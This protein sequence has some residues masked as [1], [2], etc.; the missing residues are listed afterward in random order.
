MRN[1]DK[2]M[3]AEIVLTQDDVTRTPLKIAVDRL[4]RYEPQRDGSIVTYLCE[5][6]LVT[7][8]VREAR[9]DIDALLRIA[10]RPA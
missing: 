6:G 2:K 8:L 9:A 4:V 7:A 5:A 10:A 1:R 3:S